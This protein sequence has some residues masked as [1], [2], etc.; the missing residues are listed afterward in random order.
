MSDQSITLSLPKKVDI[1]VY[2]GDSGSFR[3]T[4]TGPLGAPIDISGASWDGDIRLKAS[5]AS[6][7]TGFTFEPV[8]GDPSS[9]DVILSAESSELFTASKYVY[10][11]EM[12]EGDLVTTLIYGT[13]LAEQ[14]VSRP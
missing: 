9:V 7:I 1:T 11:I 8:V 13:I 4:M 3:I 12:R 5:D 6:P 2:Q 10:D 14:D